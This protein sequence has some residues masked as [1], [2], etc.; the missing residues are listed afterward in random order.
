MRA[1]VLVHGQRLRNSDYLLRA[2]GRSGPRRRYHA[3]VRSSWCLLVLALAACTDGPTDAQPGPSVAPLVPAAPAAAMPVA[4]VRP[5]VMVSPPQ[6]VQANGLLFEPAG[7]GPRL[8][9]GGW[10]DSAPPQCDG[11]P[12]VGLDWT[13]IDGETQASGATWGQFHVVGDFD[14]KTF[15]LTQP[16]GPPQPLAAARDMT[17][18]SPPDGRWERPDLKQATLDQV[19][20]THAA[21]RRMPGFAGLWMHNLEPQVGDVQDMKKVVLNVAF[22]GDAASHTVEL[23]KHWGGALCVVQRTK[24]ARELEQIKGAAYESASALGLDCRSSDYDETTGV[25]RVEVVHADAT[26]QA[27]LDEQYGAGVVVLESLLR[28]VPAV[29]EPLPRAGKPCTDGESL[30]DGCDC[31]DRQCMDICCVGSACSHHS[32]PEGGWPKCISLP[33]KRAK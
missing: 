14:G 28:P 30:S 22:T 12:V 4:P 16:P 19:Y 32:S 9:L 23:R 6:R 10:E 25:V 27:K 24:T 5:E 18:C 17:P 7:Q 21:A 20:A 15:T 31:R 1:A 3:G 26:H 13:K 29:P 2:P 11:L 33:K 8:C